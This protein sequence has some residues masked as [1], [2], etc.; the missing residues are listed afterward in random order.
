MT[1]NEN[2]Y[3]IWRSPYSR[4]GGLNS[5]R[6]DDTTDETVTAVDCYTDDVLREIA[7]NGFNAIWLHSVLA[8]ITH[9]DI[10]PE[11][12][13]HAELHIRNL[14]TL[15]S[16]AAKYGIRVFLYF[17]PVR[18]VAAENREF[19]NRHS[20]CAGQRE[21]ATEQ[22]LDANKDQLIDMICLCTS[23]PAVKQWIADAS[24]QLAE[25]LPE[26]GGVILITASEYPGHCYSHRR[27]KDATPWTPLIECPRCRE[28]EPWEVAA[29]LVNLVH[30]GI[31][32]H[33][34]RIE[35]IGAEASSCGACRVPLR[36]QARRGR[37]RTA[38]RGMFLPAVS[39]GR[40]SFPKLHHA[41]TRIFP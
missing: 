28:R 38:L 9:L 18:S 30:D 8:N 27:K 13:K 20:E 12:G 17:Q 26:L 41:R 29:E 34:D 37:V 4:F 10:F 31:R 36:L 39:P 16:R 22:V 5:L 11:F 32:R 3:R 21:K 24:A 1:M 7:E 19:W 25:K 35:L 33:S 40:R 14:S 6:P 15:I 23:V 2:Q